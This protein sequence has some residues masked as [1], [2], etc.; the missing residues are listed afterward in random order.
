MPRPVL[1]L[2]N[3]TKPQALAAADEVRALIQQHGRIVAEES[4]EPASP[5]TQS[6]GA[7]LIVVLGGDGTLLSQARRCAG[8]RLPMLGVNFGKVGFLAEF[9]LH[10]L[11][12]QAPALFGTAT[13]GT[14]PHHFVRTERITPARTAEPATWL[15]LNEAVITAGPPYRM[16][17]LSLSIDAE[18][19]PLLSG[20]G[21][22]VAT[23]TGSTAYNVSSGGPIVA[24]RVAAL[25]LTPIAAHSLSFRPIVVSAESVIDV[26]VMTANAGPGTLGTSLVLDGQVVCPL[27]AGDRLRFTRDPRAVHFVRNPA[28]GY[29]ST[30]I[31]KMHWGTAPSAG[32]AHPG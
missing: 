17:T 12:A 24:P 22:I 6:R 1:L 10:A 9:D 25:V 2:V 18:P 16:I 27:R 21:L 4:T 7:E 11:R 13:L 28:G 32:T 5:I 14:T 15:A 26:G 19:G 29:W 30:L 3:R 23:P 20:D 8:L 31:R